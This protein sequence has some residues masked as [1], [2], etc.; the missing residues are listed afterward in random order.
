MSDDL[1][2]INGDIAT[3]TSKAIAAGTENDHASVIKLVRAYESDLLEFGLLDFK[4]E[5]TAGRPTEYAV[6][7]EE[8]AT[9]LL[10]YMRNSEIVR[11]FK[12]ALVRA[13][14]EMKRRIAGGVA[15]PR[16]QSELI[17]ML[18]QQNVDLEVRMREQSQ[19]ITQLQQQIDQVAD[20]SAL[21]DCPQNA[22]PITAIRR[23]IGLKYGLSETIV[24]EVMRQ[25]P[26]SP[27]PAGMVVNGNENAQ[28]SKYAV[29][30]KAD[31]NKV[32]ARFVGEAKRVTETM[33]EH[34]FIANRF[35]IKKP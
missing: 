23:R 8:Q 16:S 13:F 12:K 5:S 7:N 24:N 27:K 6:L 17:L 19:A 28:G 15:A 35:R 4:S 3:T 14:Y 21:T 25:A 34:P 30:W 11:N 18:A 2:T 22:E 32:F 33:F 26:Y 29:Y 1:V 9:L 10:S 20:T 31:V